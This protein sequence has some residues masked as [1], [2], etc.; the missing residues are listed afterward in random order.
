M[1]VVV[2][3]LDDAVIGEVRACGGCADGV[4]ELVLRAAAIGQSVGEERGGA[5]HAKDTVADEFGWFVSHVA[6]LSD[7]LCG[8]H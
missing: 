5:A 3:F 4:D 2:L 7:N 1:A 6:T 8:H